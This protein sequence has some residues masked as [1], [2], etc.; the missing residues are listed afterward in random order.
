M[1]DTELTRAIKIGDRNALDGLISEYGAYTAKIVMAFFAG[2]LTAEDAEETVSDVF[3]SLWAHREDLDESRPL[4]PYLAAVARNAARK[5][6]RSCRYTE[7]LA[8]D[9][10]I[11]SALP[12]PD[13]LAEERERN[14]RLQAALAELGST[15]REIFL[16]YYYL[17][18]KIEEIAFCT[19]ILPSTIKSRLMRGREKMRKMLGESEA[20]SNA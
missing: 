7:P 8:Q 19:G 4:R 3:L 18:Q 9:E 14:E 12:S 15:D 2:K 5:R 6:L 16:R 1:T 20:E 10:E 11:A 13:R 17:E